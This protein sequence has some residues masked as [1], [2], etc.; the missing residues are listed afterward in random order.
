[1]RSQDFPDGPAVKT[2]PSNAR[3]MGLIPGQ[4]AMISRIVDK[5]PKRKTESI[6]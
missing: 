6:L 3:G 5:N 1:M 2:L 4:G